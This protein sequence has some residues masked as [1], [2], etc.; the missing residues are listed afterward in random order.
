MRAVLLN[1]MYFVLRGLL[2]SSERQSLLGAEALLHPLSSPNPTTST[3][4]HSAGLGSVEPRL[5][6]SALFLTAVGSHCWLVNWPPSQVK[7]SVSYI[8]SEQKLFPFSSFS[9]FSSFPLFVFVL[10]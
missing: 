5:M 3:T 10:L 1:G 2:L 7:P 9:S 8:V 4:S 6:L